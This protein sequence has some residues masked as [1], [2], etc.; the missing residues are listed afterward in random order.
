MFVAKPVL[1]ILFFVAIGSTAGLLYLLSQ[2]APATSPQ[3]SATTTVFVS[4]SNMAAASSSPVASSAANAALSASAEWKTAT[5]SA[6]SL[7]IDYPKDW[8]AATDSAGVKI[9]PAASESALLTI[10]REKKAKS[11]QKLA[12]FVSTRG[13]GY[14][15]D[16]YS[17]KDEKNTSIDDYSGNERSYTKDTANIREIVFATKNY[18]Y[19]VTISPGQSEN[20]AVIAEILKSI[21]II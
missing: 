10:T 15:K 14:K 21:K 8:S 18:F 17:M 19:I 12:D 5:A 13:D 16:G 3:P 2:R 20:D 4:P 11:T 7:K 6:M 9:S 1:F